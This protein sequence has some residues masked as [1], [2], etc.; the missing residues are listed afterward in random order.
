MHIIITGVHMDMTDAIRAYA[1]EKM[2]TLE[3]YVP[4]DD[5][6]GKLTVE[7]SRTSNHHAHGHVFQAEG[8]L[9]IRGKES[10]VSTTQDDLYK[11]I[12][13]LKDML[14]RELAQHKD[15]ERSVF[16]RSAHQVKELFKRLTD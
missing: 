15:K 13:L 10:V 8:I 14:I 5:T 16:R 1:L 2:R 11:A 4:K 6:S 7:L 12:D 3:K 9:H